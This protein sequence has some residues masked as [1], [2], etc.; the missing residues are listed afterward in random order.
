MSDEDGG[1]EE[2]GGGECGE[3]ERASDGSREWD[4]GDASRARGGGCAEW[5][6]SP[7]TLKAAMLDAPPPLSG[8]S[9]A[10]DGGAD[11]GVNATMPPRCCVRWSSGL[12]RRYDATGSAL[13]RLSGTCRRALPPRALLSER[14]DSNARARLGASADDASALRRAEKAADA[15]AEG[16]DGVHAPR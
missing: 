2:E 5:R 8:S 1:S 15:D 13:S 12:P 3:A 10:A 9:T 11:G 7:A 16:G 14:G 4:R 6:A